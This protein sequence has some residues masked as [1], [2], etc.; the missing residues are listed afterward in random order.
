MINNDNNRFSLAVIDDH[1]LTSLNAK[2]N[3][4]F[5]IRRTQTRLLFGTILYCRR[6]RRPSLDECHQHAR[7]MGGMRLPCEISRTKNCL[8]TLCCPLLPG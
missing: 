8:N 5:T 1:L 6:R 7:Y 4:S 2:S 3:K